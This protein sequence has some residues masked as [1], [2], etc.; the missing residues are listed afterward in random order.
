LEEKIEL[1]MLKQEHLKALNTGLQKVLD[2][3]QNH[4]LN[5]YLTPEETILWNNL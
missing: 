2:L 4:Y 5:S 1:L 3:Y